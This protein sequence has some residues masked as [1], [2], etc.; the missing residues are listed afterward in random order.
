MPKEIKVIACGVFERE[1][2]L[3]AKESR[4]ECQVELLDAGLHSRPRELKARLQD[5]VDRTPAERFERIAIFYGLCGRGTVGIIS[6]DVPLV[7]PRVHDCIGMFLGG[8]ERYWEQFR[9]CPG[10]FYM[11]PGWFENKTHPDSHRLTALRRRWSP[12]DDP[13]FPE[14]EDAYGE[15][16]AGMIAEFFHSWHRN[17]SRIALINNGL[18]DIERYRQHA[19]LLAEASGWDFEEL[20]GELAFM[21]ALAIG[22]HDDGLFLVVPPHH[23]VITTNDSRLVTAVPAAQS[24][25]DVLLA[26][27]ALSGVELGE[28]IVRGGGGEEEDGGAAGGL[29][30]GIDAG[31]T[32]TDAAV[33]D[34]ETGAVLSKAKRPTTPHD[35]SI[36]VAQAVAALDRDLLR[37]LSV[38]CLST[39]LATNAIVE[40]RGARVGLLLMP[41]GEWGLEQIRTR[42]V[43]MVPGRL[44]IDGAELEPVDPVAV[45]RAAEEL[46]GEGVEALAVS[47]YASVHNPSHEDAVKDAVRTVCD[48]PVVCGHELSAQLDF[49]RRAHTAVLNARLI[50]VIDELLRAVEHA[51][52]RHGVGAPVFVARGDGSL[53]E[54]SAARE[55]AIETILS[56]PAASAT[57]ARFLTGLDELVAV[58]IGGTTTDVAIV[59]GG[60]VSVCAEGAT[61][62]PWQTSVAAADILTSGLGGDSYVKVLEGG[63]KLEI[64]PER[65]TPLSFLADDGPGVVEHLEELAEASRY[66]YVPPTAAEFFTLV[67]VRPGLRL[68]E[69]EARLLRLLEG[70]PASP[71][72]LAREL[73]AVAI[74]LL[75]T[76]RLEGLGVVRRSAFTPTDALH[77]LGEFTAYSTAA[78]MAA[79]RILGVFVAG[80]ATYFAGLIRDRCCELLAYQV[81]RR[82]LSLGP[83]DPEGEDSEVLRALMDAMVTARADERGPFRVTFTENRTVVGIGAPAGVFIP[84]AGRLLGARVV[85]PPHAEVANAVGAVAGKV[86]VREAVSIRPNEAG[87]F[88][89]MGPLGRREFGRLR[90]AQKEAARHLVFCLRQRAEEYGT[91]QRDVSINVTERTGRLD[92]GSSQLLELVVEGLLEG[93]PHVR[94]SV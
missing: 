16:N 5:A 39:T 52:K 40:D 25:E 3:L 69:Q 64:G 94:V 28:R 26:E 38:V 37:R 13:H 47:G 24:E 7:L 78:A 80:D 91:D 51:L 1:L 56:G 70:G 15:E 79:A 67:R 90:D 23:M 27:R 59:S 76:R 11:T 53:I 46:L 32:Y 68:S 48:L 20:Q 82:E 62:G 58:D 77:V 61:V 29:G 45:R 17:Y 88:I 92:D 72:R 36:G 19:H 42:P 84:E 63:T 55:R 8:A 35:L 2:E 74:G 41:V 30:L 86:I 14:W 43:R 21:R 60:R 73:G 22:P 9:A 31:G 81:M 54:M 87:S 83:G 57:G 50:P 10:T 75:P 89:M 93:P 44:S 34:F 4:L 33:V 66:E 6:R 18:G 65:V 71:Q 12:R 49:V 85:V